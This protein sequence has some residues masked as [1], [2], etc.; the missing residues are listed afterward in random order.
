[1][2]ILKSTLVISCIVTAMG[3]CLPAFAQSE[4]RSTR[5]PVSFSEYDRDGDGRISQEEF[6]S[7]RDTRMQSRTK[8]GRSMRGKCQAPTFAEYDTD[9]DGMLSPAE[10]A[11][12]Q[13]KM[14]KGRGG[15]CAGTGDGKR[16][17]RGMSGGTGGSNMPTFADFDLNGD[18]VIHPQ[19]FNDA[20]AKRVSERTKEGHPMR[21]VGHMPTFSDIDS[22]GDGEIS[23]EEFSA[24]QAQHRQQMKP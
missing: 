13:Q 11:A 14:R 12:G 2:N 16:H 21:N 6:E 7:V 24:Y 10:L 17:G 8:Q 3:I 22:N 4:S 19:E 1:M 20:R 5:V 18:G 23:P 15:A 9:G